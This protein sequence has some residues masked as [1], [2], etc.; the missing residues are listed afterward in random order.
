MGAPRRRW[1]EALP[2]RLRWELSEMKRVAP[3]LL[4]DEG[5]ASWNGLLP[6]WPFEREAPESLAG[7]LNGNRFRVEIQP[8]PAHPA[9]PPR[10][11]PIEPNPGPWHWTDAA[12]HTLGDGSLCVVQEHYTW[13]G[14]EPC[15]ALIPT[16][17]GWFLEY[18]LMEGGVIEAMTVHGIETS[19]ELDHLFIADNRVESP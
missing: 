2:G 14:G 5:S 13:T 15:A 18:L 12:W 16:A 8:L 1:T 10:I 6:T 11:W 19:C 17:A 7:F 9:V 3:E 4:W